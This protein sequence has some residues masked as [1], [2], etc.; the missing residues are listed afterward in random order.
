MNIKGNGSFLYKPVIKEIRKQTTES[1]VPSTSFLIR[2]QHIDIP[3]MTVWNYTQKLIFITNQNQNR[4]YKF[5]F[6]MYSRK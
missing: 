5:F 1:V 6:E 3:F 4:K 2:P